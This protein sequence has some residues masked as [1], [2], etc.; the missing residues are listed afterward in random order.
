MLLNAEPQTI[1]DTDITLISKTTQ[2][3]VIKKLTMRQQL[4]LRIPSNS[5]NQTNIK[6]IQV[7]SIIIE[8]KKSLITI[9]KKN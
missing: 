4:L 9:S 6:H 3:G 1:Y 7:R 2:L 8:D 5:M